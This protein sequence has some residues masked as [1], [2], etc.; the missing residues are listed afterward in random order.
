MTK[1]F[2][3]ALTFAVLNA[4]VPAQAIVIGNLGSS[5][6]SCYPFG[7]ATGTGQF[8][9]SYYYSQ[10]AGPMNFS[11]LKVFGQQLPYWTNGTNLS[12][13][14]FTVSLSTSQKFGFPQDENIGS[15][16]TVVYSGAL[17]T[18]DASGDLTIRFS[19]NFYYDPR[20]ASDLLMDI[21]WTGAA[22]SVRPV[23]F[24]ESPGLV[25][26][27]LNS[28]DDG[29]IRYSGLVTEFV[30]VP[31]PASIALLGVGVLA[32]GVARRKRLTTM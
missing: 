7:C 30:Q 15:N 28:A 31:E 6:D 22:S 18:L 10:F 21:K 2:A 24:L 12:S 32:I 29:F 5:D 8:Q 17:G 26:S 4:F 9:Q 23:Y 20:T 27:S 25:M 13:G 19:Q 14:T 1:I 16:N 3:A 11:A